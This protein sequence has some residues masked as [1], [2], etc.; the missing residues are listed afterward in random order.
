MTTATRAKDAT[1]HHHEEVT[2][3]YLLTHDLGEKYQ[4]LRFKGLSV[5]EATDTIFVEV[6]AELAQHIKSLIP[7]DQLNTI[8]VRDLSTKILSEVAR[9]SETEQPALERTID[10]DI[11]MVSTCPEIAV[12]KSGRV[13][14]VNRIVDCAGTLIGIGPRPGY[15][16]LE[17]QIAN[18]VQAAGG[19]PIVIVEDGSFTGKTITGLLHLFENAIK[20]QDKTSGILHTH[21]AAIILGFAFPKAISLL[22]ANNRV[23]VHIVMPYAD[24]D[25]WMPDHDFVPFSPNCGRIVGH[26]VNDQAYPFYNHNGVPYGVPYIYPYGTF[27]MVREWTG[28][29]GVDNDALY[30]FSVHCLRLADEIYTHLEQLNG[31]EITLGHLKGC[32]PRISMPFFVKRPARELN[33]PIL[34][35][36]DIGPNV[37]VLDIIRRSRRLAELQFA[38]TNK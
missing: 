35:G 15:P 5:P 14:E 27:E 29:T 16:T 26:I 32:N 6:Q 3:T 18:I 34:D 20:A 4:A 11:L 7:N 10:Q 21:V 8:L 36:L 38:L 30:R 13:L 24:L 22:E 28:F 2:K 23:D 9:L 33:Q 31:H 37:R 17:N 1:D 12:P 19:R 25:D